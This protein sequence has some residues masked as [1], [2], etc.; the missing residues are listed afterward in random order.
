MA[1][2]NK[3]IVIALGNT[4]RG[5]D[6]VGPVVCEK[7]KEFCLPD[8]DIVRSSG[9]AMNLIGLWEMSALAIV[10]DASVSGKRAGTIRRLE[11]TGELLEKDIARCSTHGFGVNEAIGLANALNK[12]PEKLILY[13]IE[14]EVMENGASL[15]P[16]VKDAISPAAE[17]IRFE[18]IYYRD[19]AKNA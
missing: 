6:G 13:T 2:R 12:M 1:S 8:V 7:L 14:A 11:S 18:V 3:I 4:M 5:D 9:D 15:S 19:G 17:Q 16:L 10:V